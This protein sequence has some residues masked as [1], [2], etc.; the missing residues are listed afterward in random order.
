MEFQLH[1]RYAHE[2]Q[3]MGFGGVTS[4]ADRADV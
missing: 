1:Q 2:A 4:A 3:P